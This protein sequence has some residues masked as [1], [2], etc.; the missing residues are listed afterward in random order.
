MHSGAHTIGVTH[1]SSF[2][3]RLYSGDNNNSDN[4]GHDPAMDDA[5]AT[6]LARRCPPGSADTVPMDLGGGGGPVDENAFDTGYFQ[7]LLA[8]RGLLGSD[9]ALTADNATA[10]LVAQ[11]AGN[12]Y[13]FVTRFADAM[14]RMGAVRVLTG[15]DGQIRTSCRVVN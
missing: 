2:S 12:L 1:C 9:Q 7:A 8:H 10:A 6:E 13:L 15:S 4:T 11:N 5:T 14:V 3:A